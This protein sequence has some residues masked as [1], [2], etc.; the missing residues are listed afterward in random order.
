LGGRHL[1]IGLGWIRI[2]GQTRGHKRRFYP[3]GAY[4]VGTNAIECVIQRQTFGKS[5][6]RELGGA[7]G[8]PLLDSRDAADRGHIYDHAVLFLDHSA[9]K[10]P[11]QIKHTSDVNKI[12]A[13]EVFGRR[14]LDTPDMA[15]AGVVDENVEP[16]MLTAHCLSSQRALVVFR[17]IEGYIRRSVALS[18]DLIRNPLAIALVNV[19]NIDKGPAPCE[20]ARDRLTYARAGT[21]H[22]RYLI[23]EVKHPLAR[24]YRV[25]KPAETVDLDLDDIPILYVNRRF[26]GEA[27]A[28][29]CACRN[30]VARF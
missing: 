23:V 11:R 20:K 8:D 26:T 15:N 24:Y 7:V 27:D 19:R 10:G 22:E 14:D 18:N 25:G 2:F 6:D 30:D 21:S 9:D 28:R 16:T 13:V 29:R 5:D 4:T 12:K 1:G 17:N 3:T